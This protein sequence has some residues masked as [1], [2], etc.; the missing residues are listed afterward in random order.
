MLVFTICFA[1]MTVMVK[2]LRHLPLMEIIFFRNLPI[3]LII[4]LI[5][6]NKKIP[7]CGNN[8]PLLLLRCL[9]G[10]LTMVAYFYTIT[11]MALADAVTV[12]QLSPFFILILARIFL[13]KRWSQNKFT[14]LFLRL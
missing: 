6:K 14:L 10:A 4:P 12:K 8:R 2:F 11:V 7:F 1:S 5:L 13:R 3:M 9:F